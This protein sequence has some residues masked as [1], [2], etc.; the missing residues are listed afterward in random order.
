MKVWMRPRRWLLIFTLLAL[1][2]AGC[3]GK[4]VGHA[5]EMRLGHEAARVIEQRFRVCQDQELQWLVERIGRRIA[6][7]SSRSDV[8]FTFRVL[9]EREINALSVPGYVYVNRGLINATNAN[10]DELA[11]VIAHEV[12]H[13]TERHMA[14]QMERVYGATFLLNAFVTENANINTLAEIAVELALRGNSRQDERAADAQAV[15]FMSRA[16]YDP[17]GMVR[18]FERLL[19]ETGDT[20]GLNKYLSTHPSTS[21]RISRIRALIEK[22]DLAR[23]ALQP[24]RSSDVQIADH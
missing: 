20:R 5:E 9:E 17:Y 8:D 12:A 13:T 24:R 18:F 21:E 2:P 19:K 23:K 3:G 6:P 1:F 15:R 11:A 4:L 10:P 7:S 16:G 14:K 22:E